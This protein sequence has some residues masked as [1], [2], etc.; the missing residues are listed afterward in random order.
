MSCIL[1]K[2][3]LRFDIIHTLFYS[4]PPPPSLL[5]GISSL[6]KVAKNAAVMSNRLLGEQEWVVL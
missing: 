2:G 6:I 3:D 5:F 4:C 1:S